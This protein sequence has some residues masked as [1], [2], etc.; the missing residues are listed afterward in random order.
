[1][2]Y[3]VIMAGGR[4]ERFWPKS[5][6]SLPKQFLC[7]GKKGTVLQNTLNRLKGFLGAGQN[8]HHYGTELPEYCS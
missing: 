2:P 1:M 6:L 3:A 4:G 7:L 5:R 8:M